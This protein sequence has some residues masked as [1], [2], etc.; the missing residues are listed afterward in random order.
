MHFENGSD[1]IEIADYLGVESFR[2]IEV[3]QRGSATLLSFAEG[4]VEL[5]GFESRLIDASDF[6]FL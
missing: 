4:T 2:D 5:A 3:L 6:H 1:H